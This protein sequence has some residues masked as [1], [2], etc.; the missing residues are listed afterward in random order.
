MIDKSVKAWYAPPMP[1]EPDTTLLKREAIVEAACK[2]ARRKG[3]HRSRIT[4]IAR[5]AGISYGL[6]YHY[7][8]SKAALFDAIADEW[9]GGLFGTMDR[10]LERQGS[11]RERLSVLVDFFLD[12]YSRRPFLVQFFVAEISRSSVNL[13]KQRLR[14]FRDLMT[15]TESIMTQGQ[16]EGTLRSDIR[17]RYLTYFFLGA[18]ESFLSAMVLEN[19]PLKDEEQQARIATGVLTVFFDGASPRHD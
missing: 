8:G 13:T 10:M 6:V 12:Q 17:A 4:D 2:V 7:F 5:E 18:L 16:Q 1:H 11:A 15:K 14:P 9:W 19:L 3:F